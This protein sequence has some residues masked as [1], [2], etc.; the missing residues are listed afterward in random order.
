VSWS[1]RGIFDEKGNL[2]EILCVGVD[3]TEQKHIRQEIEE[4]RRLLDMAVRGLSRGV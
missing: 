4:S 1:N 3:E 2:T